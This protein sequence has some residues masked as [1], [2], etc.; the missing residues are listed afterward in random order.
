MV[1]FEIFIVEF[2][3]VNRLSPSTIVL[4]EVPSL[5][6]E[7]RDNPMEPTPLLVQSVSLFSGAEAPEVLRCYW[8]DVAIELELDSA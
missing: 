4:G 7:L 2:V 1:L 8:D 6:H 5:E 3:P